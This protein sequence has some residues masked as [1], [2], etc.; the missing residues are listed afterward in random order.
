MIEKDAADTIHAVSFPIV[1][2]QIKSGDLT[3]AI[4]RARMKRRGFLLWRFFHFA[5][6][7]RRTGE[8]ETA[9]R[10]KFAQGCQKIMGAIN[11]CIH[12][13]ES[14]GKT[15]GDKALRSQVI[16]LVE[17]VTADD[18]KD[19]GITFQGGRMQRESIQQMRDAVKSALRILQ[20]HAPH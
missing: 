8:I 7:F 10:L 18:M 19:T 3:D 15:F 20:R 17:F 2:R 1:A 14:V 9:L 11:I 13:R 16:T 4:R 6:H 12:R 5:K